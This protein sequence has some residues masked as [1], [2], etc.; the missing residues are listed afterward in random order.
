MSL[1]VL[2][3]E[4]AA[5]S[6][7]VDV[8]QDEIGS[9]LVPE[10][11]GLVS[12]S[13]LEYVIPRVAQGGLQGPTN[14]GVVIHYQDQPLGSLRYL[15]VRGPHLLGSSRDL[16]PHV[17]RRERYVRVATF[18][19]PEPLPVVAHRIVPVMLGT[20]SGPAFRLVSRCA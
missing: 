4:K 8:G 18:D 5:L 1:K 9:G 19:Y 12:V 17:A 15:E 11:G 16:D 10:L 2:E 20:K 13:R 3:E 7:H 6:G 14:G